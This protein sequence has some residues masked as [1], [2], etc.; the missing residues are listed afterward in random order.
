MLVMSYVF[1]KGRAEGSGFFS[2]YRLT[3]PDVVRPKDASLFHP[4]AEEVTTVIFCLHIK[5]L[6]EMF[7]WK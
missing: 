3:K 4:I 6:E 1:L 5:F 7:S 2:L